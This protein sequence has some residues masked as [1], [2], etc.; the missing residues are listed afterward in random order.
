MTSEVHEGGCLC[1][2]VRYKV[3]G[4]PVQGS[5]CHCRFCQVR[6]GS[7]FAAMGYFREE[8]VEIRGELKTYEHRSDTS[9]RWLRIQFCPTCGT[10]V[11]HVAELRPGWRG[12]SAGTFDQPGWFPHTKHVWTRSKHAWVG[13]PEEAEAFPQGSWTKPAP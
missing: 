4:A 2:A 8:D 3:S 7:A 5:V 1:G 6:S 10:P 12:I 9:G 13:I 11:T